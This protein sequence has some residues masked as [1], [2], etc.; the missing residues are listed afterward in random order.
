MGEN[1]YNLRIYKRNDKGE[2]E[3]A[4]TLYGFCKLKDAFEV[5]AEFYNRAET[6][7]EFNFA[8]FN[9]VY[10]DCTDELVEV[11][12][13]NDSANYRYNNKVGL[14]LI[15]KYLPQINLKAAKK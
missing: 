6:N 14:R 4:D 5:G 15:R 3:R 1:T 8:G 12:F 9:I 13:R 7:P 2:F 10:A 11:I